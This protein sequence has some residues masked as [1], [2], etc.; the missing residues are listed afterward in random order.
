MAGIYN[1]QQLSSKFSQLWSEFKFVVTGLRLLYPVLD[2][3]CS[4]QFLVARNAVVEALNMG[5]SRPAIIIDET[6]N[7]IVDGRF[8]GGYLYAQLKLPSAN[9]IPPFIH[10]DTSKATFKAF[11]K[12]IEEYSPDVLL[13]L[14]NFPKRWLSEM[15]IKVPKLIGF[16]QLEL[17]NGD[18]QEVGVNQHNDRVGEVAVHRLIELLNAPSDKQFSTATF[19]EPT[20]SNNN[21]QIE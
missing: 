17:R 5:Y 2:Y 11:K 16:I 6:I 12:W 4:D 15:G 7:N 9:K 8:I 1:Y 21:L 18:V 20:W 13:S 3:A 10:V 19:V 14:Y